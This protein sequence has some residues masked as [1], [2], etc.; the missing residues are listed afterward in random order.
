MS[1]EKY[2][3]VLDTSGKQSGT[4]NTG[5]VYSTFNLIPT[6][7]PFYMKLTMFNMV[8]AA[9]NISPSKGNTIQCDDG[10]N[11][12]TIVL[13]TGAYG[14]G[15]T[16]D[17]GNAVAAALTTANA[18][19]AAI[20]FASTYNDATNLYTLNGTKPFKLIFN[21]NSIKINT[22]LTTVLLHQPLRRQVDIQIYTIIIFR[23]KYM[24]IMQQL[25]TL[26]SHRIRE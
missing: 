19:L 9:P 13:P 14:V 17:L 22:V 1:L 12:I 2:V 10:A 24:P 25:N 3:F 5:S 18:G 16:N 15:S 21:S 8:F 23:Y 20:T 7:E 6:T 26:K 11:I 4:P